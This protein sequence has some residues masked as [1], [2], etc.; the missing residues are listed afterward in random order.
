MKTIQT[1]FILLATSLSL[2]AQQSDLRINEVLD[3]L[4][5]NPIT[6]SFHPEGEVLINT[7]KRIN[8][9]TDWDLMVLSDIEAGQVSIDTIP[10][11]D[12]NRAAFSRGG[13]Y[14]IHN[15]KDLVSDSWKTVKRRYYG[16][17]KAGSPVDLSQALFRDGMFYYY[18]MDEQE[19][20]YYYQY[21]RENRPEGGVLFSAFENGRYLKP[22]MIH[23]DRPNAV[24]YSPYLLDDHTM[25]FAQHGIK[26]RTYRGIHYSVK[27]EDGKW[28]APAL[29]PD[30][31]MSNVVTYY[32]DDTVAFLS[33]ENSRV[34]TMSRDELFKMIDDAQ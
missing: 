25:I 21:V 32:D 10:A 1:L 2:N 27:D 20:F 19:N 28:S 16:N 5:M 15:T 7:S 26:D 6:I 33:A 3:S 34:F 17:G 18:F 9:N 8:N 12:V 29:L 30:V 11:T 14:L 13:R 4:Q 22:Q 23:P 24:A 31:P